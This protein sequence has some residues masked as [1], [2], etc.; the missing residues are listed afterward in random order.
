MSLKTRNLNRHL[1]AQNQPNPPHVIVHMCRPCRSS[2]VFK[3]RQTLLWNPN[4]TKL[5][6]DVERQILKFVSRFWRSGEPSTAAN[7]YNTGMIIPIWVHTSLVIITKVISMQWRWQRRL[8]L[9]SE[10]SPPWEKCSTASP[11]CW[12]WS[13]GNIAAFAYHRIT[14]IIIT[15]II[16]VS[17][18]IFEN[19]QSHSL[20]IYN[21][22]FQNRSSRIILQDL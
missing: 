5:E 8:S 12:P 18:I 19:R 2:S 9:N 14:I 7:K 21:R 4:V 22:S 10:L 15:I 20:K 11:L 1:P 16:T 3:H 6:F 17:I 13:G